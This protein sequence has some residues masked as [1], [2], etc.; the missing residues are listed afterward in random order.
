MSA[1]SFTTLTTPSWNMEGWND[2]FLPVENGNVSQGLSPL[3]DTHFKPAVEDKPSKKL[4]PA[5]ERKHDRAR[6]TSGRQSNIKPLRSK[7]PLKKVAN[8][9][10]KRANNTKA[11]RRSRHKKQNYVEGLERTVEELQALLLKT[12]QERDSFK[13]SFQSL[14]AFRTRTA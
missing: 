2:C 14:Q 10:Q 5:K 6:T 8:A 4:Q 1:P 13:Q 7:D 11:A 3:L 9:E 12:T